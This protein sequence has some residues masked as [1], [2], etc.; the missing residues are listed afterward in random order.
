M[1]IKDC[2]L[3]VVI[4]IA[5]GETLT[6]IEFGVLIVMI[7]VADF[8]PSETEVAVTVTFA[9]AGATTGAV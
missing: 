9:G 8:V 1:E 7:A 2:V 3:C 5:T 6:E 4:L